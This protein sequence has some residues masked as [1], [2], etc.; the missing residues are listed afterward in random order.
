MSSGL[1][2]TYLLPG[3][4]QVQKDKPAYHNELGAYGWWSEVIKRTAIGAGADPQGMQP[5]RPHT[6][7]T[8]GLT[9]CMQQWKHP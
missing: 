4:K 2:L 9:G 6:E 1:C 7:N 5:F 3:L 8:W